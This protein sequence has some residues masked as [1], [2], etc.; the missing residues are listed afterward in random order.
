MMEAA[1]PAQ[2]MGRAQAVPQEASGKWFVTFMW[3]SMLIPPGFLYAIPILDFYLLLSMF[4]QNPAFHQM[5]RYQVITL[6]SLNVIV[7]FSFLILIFLILQVLCD[8]WSL[9]GL[10]MRFAGLV[11][12]NYDFCGALSN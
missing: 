8:P 12:K 5:K 6:I 3:R 2:S 11:N 7:I 1:A 4:S 9:A 10:G